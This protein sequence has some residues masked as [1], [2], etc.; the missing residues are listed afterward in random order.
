VGNAPR[1]SVLD[2]GDGA[3]RSH[4]FARETH[5]CLRRSRRVRALDVARAV[6]TTGA[7]SG[8]VLCN[9][10]GGVTG[11][12]PIA[13]GL[14]LICLVIIRL[15]VHLQLGLLIGVL[16]W[17]VWAQIPDDFPRFTV[18]GHER[19]MATVRA[20]FWL[21]YPGSGPKATL[22]DEWLSGP[23]LWP[24]VAGD[25]HA[26]AEAFRSQWRAALSQRII[27]PEGYVA[28][29]QHASIAHPLGWPFPFWNQGSRGYGW[30]FSF[31]DTVGP[32]W[33]PD[34]LNRPDDWTLS[35]ARDLGTN[36]FGWRWS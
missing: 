22:W 7:R 13:L 1:G 24:A 4:L 14:P 31:K 21:H 27:D 28:T 17:A 29:H 11:W 30:H 10:D 18:P 36:D 25:A 3:T 12:L 23:A 8:Q 16:P 6:P 9:R 19:E 32:P 5:P 15:S 2:C 26:N 35:G 20:L 34:H 33:R